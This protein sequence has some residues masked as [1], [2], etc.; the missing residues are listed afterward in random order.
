MLSKIAPI[1]IFCIVINPIVKASSIL[2]NNLIPRKILFSSPK[3]SA[4]NF[5]PDGKYLSYMVKKD[6]NGCIYIV[7]SDNPKNI[8]TT[9]ETNFSNNSYSWGYDNSHIFYYKRNE[10]IN[11]IQS[12]IVMI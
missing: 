8:I 1:I 6:N 11:N 5:S 2:Q 3:Y 7:D 4:L 9:I 10:K 12:F